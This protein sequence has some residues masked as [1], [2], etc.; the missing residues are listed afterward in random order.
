MNEQI[1]DIKTKLK[2]I[3]DYRTEGL[4]LRSRTKWYEKGERSN[5]F[6]LTLASQ[7]KVKTT[8]NKVRVDNKEIT[9]QHEILKAQAKF[10]EELYKNKCNAKLEDIKAYI[11]AEALPVLDDETKEKCE[12]L[13]TA[14]ECIKV[15]KTMKK[16]KSPGNDGLTVEFYIKFWGVLSK[17]YLEAINEAY[18]VRRTVMFTKTSCYNPDR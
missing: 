2:E 7:N 9:D 17:Y 15:L 12:G 13:I 1:N 10:Y 6:F 18:L 11:N 5:K 14:E 8:M 16:C 3:D 4:I